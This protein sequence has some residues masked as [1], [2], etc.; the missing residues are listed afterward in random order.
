M[1][2]KNKKGPTRGPILILQLKNL[3]DSSRLAG[4]MT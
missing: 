4:S 3:F 1:V 2:L